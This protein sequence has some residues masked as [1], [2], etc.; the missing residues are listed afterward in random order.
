[1]TTKFPHS[2]KPHSALLRST[3]QVIFS[4]KIWNGNNFQNF[5]AS[6]DKTNSRGEVLRHSEWRR[7][8]RWLQEATCYFSTQQS[9][10]FQ[11]T[12][13]Q[14]LKLLQMFQPLFIN[15]CSLASCVIL[16]WT[17]KE[18]SVLLWQKYEEALHFFISYCVVLIKRGTD[19]HATTRAFYTRIIKW[20]N[21]TF[22]ILTYTCIPYDISTN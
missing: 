5:V 17:M 6:R 11:V 16:L 13:H 10:S 8:P 9:F 3:F 15:L 1:M 22:L 20:I 18:F 4:T 2:S 12:Q 19:P 21:M 7:K 14:S